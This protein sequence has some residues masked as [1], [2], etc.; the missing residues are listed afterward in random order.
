MSKDDVKKEELEQVSGGKVIQGPD[1]TV[2]QQCYYCTNK[3]CNNYHLYH[4]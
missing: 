4:K 1:C 2:P 3:D